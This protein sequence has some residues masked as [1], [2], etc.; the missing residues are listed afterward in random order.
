MLDGRLHGLFGHFV[1]LNPACLGFIHAQHMIQMPADG[2]PFAVR[3]CREIDLGSV[4]GFLPDPAQDIAAAADC[5]VFQFK[6]M[7]GINTELTFGQVT[8]MALGGF[9]FIAFSQVTPDRL[10]FGGRFH[11]DQF[12]FCR[13][14]P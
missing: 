5:D 12:L 1:E 10:C 8:D 2:F 9:H 4:L 3:V 6:V 11:N 14:H 13:C 7:I